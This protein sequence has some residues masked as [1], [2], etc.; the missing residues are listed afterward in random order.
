MK[1]ELERQVWKIQYKCKHRAKDGHELFHVKCSVCG[2]EKELAKTDIQN[3]PSCR[4]INFTDK[5]IGSIFSGMKNRCYNKN[6]KNYKYYGA[7]NIEICKE[8]LLRPY[9]FEEWAFKNGYLS[10]L[11]IDRIDVNEGYSPENCRWVSINNNSRYKSTTNLI[12]VNGLTL[13][14][15]QWSQFLNIGINSINR[16]LRTRGKEYTYN[17]I[18]ERLNE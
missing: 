17:F 12:A 4:H 5:R 16:Y 7:K 9:L 6:D 3:T 13:T 8:W 14:G 15:R 18:L 1:L 2:I 11:S 10:S